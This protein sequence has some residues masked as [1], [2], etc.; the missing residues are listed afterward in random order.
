MTSVLGG[1][2]GVG[3]FGPLGGVIGVVLPLAWRWWRT[4]T[5][6]SP[7]LELVLLVLLV[8]L[9][10]GLSVLAALLQVSQALPAHSNL[11]I[12]ARVAT[13]D[14]LVAA[15]EVA[16]P[17]LRPVLSHLARAQRT[18][19]SLSGAVRRLLEDHLASDRTKRI[20]KARAL[21][22]RLMIPVTLLMLPGLVLMLY[23]P[24]LLSMFRDLTGTLT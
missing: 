3:L 6:P 21:P 9:R 20:A 10:S 13:V 12:V 11:K 8:E 16:D 19:A 22:V 14:G 7:P 23:A 15:S 18:G 17:E 5:E 1:A 4:R 24:S 2:V